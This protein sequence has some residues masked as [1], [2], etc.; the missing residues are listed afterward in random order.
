MTISGHTFANYNKI[1]H[2]TEVQTVLFHSMARANLNKS[3]WL[4][5]NTTTTSK[6]YLRGP[7]SASIEI[8]PQTSLHKIFK[9]CFV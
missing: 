6:S 3:V 7:E 4:V 8:P 9:N 5:T 2:K 1:F